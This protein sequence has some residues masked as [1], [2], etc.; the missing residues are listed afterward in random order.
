M[1]KEK[2]YSGDLL[3]IG[4]GVAGLTLTKILGQEGIEIHIVEPYPPKN[5]DKTEASSRTVALMQ[6]SLNVLRAA[7]LDQFI[8]EYG[9]KMNMMRIIDDSIPAQ[10][11][12]ECEFDS[13]DLGLEYFSMNIPNSLLRARLF[14]DITKLKNV[15]IHETSLHDYTQSNFG[16]EAQLENGAKGDL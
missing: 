1:S 8:D 10:D 11:T 6:S 13:F 5:F 15:T 7:G 14:E 9:T 2:N 16:V 3:I 12:L 4:G